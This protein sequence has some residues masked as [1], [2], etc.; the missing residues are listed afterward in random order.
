MLRPPADAWALAA[1]M[2]SAAGSMPVTLAPSRAKGSQTSP[3]PADVEHAQAREASGLLGVAPKPL[4]QLVADIGEP[5]RIDAVKLPKRPA[6]VPP[7]SGE[8]CKTGHLIAIEGL[9]V[10][11]GVRHKP[12]TV[13]LNPLSRMAGEGE[14][15]LRAAPAVSMK[16]RFLAG[17]GA[18]QA[19]AIGQWR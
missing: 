11:R 15:R 10:L 18:G 8:P 7:V 4:A 2:F 3:P 1:A 16:N 13:G 17:L 19:V 6:L 12:L 14:A 5:H 9:G